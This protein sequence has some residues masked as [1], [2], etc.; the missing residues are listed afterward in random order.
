MLYLETRVEGQVLRWSLTPGDYVLGRSPQ[1]DIVVPHEAV[2]R[3]HA[4]IKVIDGTLV[5]EDLGS[6]HGLWVGSNR[7]ESLELQAPAEFSIANLRAAVRRGIT[8]DDAAPPSPADRSE[9]LASD[10][11]DQLAQAFRARSA[12]VRSRFDLS[13]SDLES[14]LAVL[15]GQGP[16]SAL[17]ERWLELVVRA[18]GARGGMLLAPQGKTVTVLASWGELPQKVLGGRCETEDALL[19]I[20]VSIGEQAEAGRVVLHPPPPRERLTPVVELLAQLAGAACV[21]AAGGP[22]D[23]RDPSRPDQERESLSTRKALSSSIEDTEFVAFSESSCRLLDEVD[24]LAAASL[25]VF[26]CGESGTGKE[27]I[28]RR[29]HARS[30]RS[31]GPFVAIN[32]A[33]LPADLLEAELFGIGKGVATGVS[34]RIGWLARASG[35]TLFLDEVGDLPDSLQP[36]LLRALENGHVFEVGS[37]EPTPIDV[38]IVSASHMDLR[39]QAMQGGFRTDLLFRLAGATL[40]IPPL[41]DRPEEILP[42]VQRFV[43][44]SSRRH[45]RRMCG[46]DLDAARLLAGYDWPG[47]VRELSFTV[48]RAVALADGPVIHVGLLPEEIASSADTKLGHTLVALDEDWRTARRSFDRLYFDNLMRK[49]DGNI[50]EVSR[51]AGLSRS[52]LYRQLQQLGLKP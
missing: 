31:D 20:P 45:G 34:E 50:S 46:I 49:S 44:W 29:V 23:E 47:N 41:R 51:K 37:R 14:V 35:G 24:G 7:M 15:R 36:K 27:L 38:R 33:A 9:P 2:S 4:A 16:R 6:R 40:H 18:A 52:S 30:A 26:I 5:C 22:G 39:Q 3:R 13:M 43:S 48:D 17:P 19:A 21:S 11:S 32:C 1:C 8:V 12:A 28:A 10:A 25:P 42:L